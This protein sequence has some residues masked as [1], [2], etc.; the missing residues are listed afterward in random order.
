MLCNVLRSHQRLGNN[1]H[2]RSTYAMR[3]Q[4]SEEAGFINSLSRFCAWRGGGSDGGAGWAGVSHHVDHY[5][6]DGDDDD[7]C[8]DDADDNDEQGRLGGSEPLC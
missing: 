4:E 8:V 1:H 2:P 7:D 5:H 3:R 6:Y